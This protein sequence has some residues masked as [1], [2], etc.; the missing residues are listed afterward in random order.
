M[1]LKSL[2]K[3]YWR[4][5]GGLILLLAILGICY[6][7]IMK[8]V[9]RDF[10]EEANQRLYGSLADTTV[11]LVRP[12]V[13]GDVDTLAIQDIMH[14]LMVINPSIE[15]YLLDTTGYIIT[16]VAPKKKIKRTHVGLEPLKTFIASDKAQTFIKGDDPRDPDKEKVFSAAPILEDGKL[17]GYL[18]IILASEQQEA[19]STNVSQSYMLRVGIGLFILTLIGALL[20]GLIALWYLTSNLRKTIRVVQQFKDGDYE[21]RVPD[22][23]LKDLEPLGETFNTMA[24][25]IVANI[26]AL[27][28]V[29]R[30]RKELIANVSHDL[31]T[32]LT[33][34]QGYIETLLMKHGTLE[35]AQREQ[36]LETALKST[37]NLEKLVAQL[38][39]LTKLEAQQI[40][41]E[42]EPFFIG[43]LAQDV[44][45]QYQVLA[46]EKEIGLQFEMSGEQSLVFADVSMVARVLQNLLDNALKFTPPGGRVLLQ[47][48]GENEQV[49]VAIADSGPGIPVPDQPY[50]FDRYY[51]RKNRKKEKEGTGLGLAIVKKILDL[52]ECQIRVFSQLEK[53]ATFV[54]QLPRYDYQGAG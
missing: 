42:K 53:G 15:V 27:K 45:Q 51:Q 9:E 41:P 46:K 47:V 28:S 20:I 11:N 37:K 2:P 17:T 39:E 3:I 48:T 52:H 29:E 22:N 40:T 26:E 43:E 33:V 31:R 32:P 34:V 30:L 49:K 36:I 24:D 12:L 44:V 1:T 21:A 4:I 38:F 16:Y 23:Q 8:Y 5:S 6:V 18:Y 10:I 50:I 13:D 54:F 35:K 14:S 19:V 7:S 25:T